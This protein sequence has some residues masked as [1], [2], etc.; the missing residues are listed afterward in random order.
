M[1]LEKQWHAEVVCLLKDQVSFLKTELSHKNTLIENLIIE[2]STR[3]N[4]GSRSCSDFNNDSN[5][6]SQLSVSSAN[7]D[8][9]FESNNSETSKPNMEKPEDILCTHRFKTLIID[10]ESDSDD[11]LQ[12]NGI[13]TTR[14]ASQEDITRQKKNKVNTKP[15]H[16][17]EI[18]NKANHVPGNSSYSEITRGGKKILILSDS[19]CNRIR[20]KEFNQYI[21]N[22]YAYHKNF[23]GATSK[24]IAHY[25][26]PAL[27][28][29]KPD[30]CIIHVG[31]NS[32]NKE[33]PTEI[34]N[35]TLNIV[36]I[37][38]SYGVN[39]MCV[40]YYIPGKL[41]RTGK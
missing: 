26:L 11:V 24:D 9:T 22:G 10:E 8:N 16:K 31:T 21:T 35:D 30:M 7:Y 28:D 1:H 25:C 41:S 2:L 38:R 27:I 37:C 18:Y 33:N 3:S 40:R 20:M 13:K 32:L 4:N 23:P 39:D 5:N 29:D 19:L 12:N 17:N 36:E 34:V 14:Y 15:K 6:V